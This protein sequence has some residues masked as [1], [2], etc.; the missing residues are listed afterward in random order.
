MA[1]STT[2]PS[3]ALISPSAIAKL[4]GVSAA[5][6]SNWRKRAADFPE[7]VAGDNPTRPLFARD[8][9]IAW[10][11]ANNKPIVGREVADTW[12]MLDT[13]RSALA[14][15]Q[16]ALVLLSLCAAR[17]LCEETPSP[18]QSWADLQAQAS[19]NGFEALRG[20]GNKLT[21]TRWD[22]LVVLGDEVGDVRPDAAA[23]IA[24]A[25]GQIP[26]KEL[27]DVADAVLARAV[28][29]LGRG[30]SELG[31]IGNPVS[32]FLAAISAGDARGTVYDPA[33]GIADVLIQLAAARSEA[34]DRLVGHD[35]NREVVTV[36]RQ[37]AYLHDV[38][39][40]L[41][42]TDVLAD[43]V[44]PDLTADLIVADPPYGVKFDGYD[45]LDPRWVYGTSK[46]SAELAWI[47]HAIAHLADD[48][49][50]YVATP[51]GTLF[52]SREKEIRRKLIADGCIQAI[53]QLP[54]RLLQHTSIAVAVWVLGKPGTSQSIRFVNADTA[55]VTEGRA[56]FESSQKSA[57]VSIDDVL[58]GDAN[59]VPER[60]IGM[61]TPDPAEV[62]SSYT[63]ALTRVDSS[64]RSVASV[65][66]QKFDATGPARIMT[67]GELADQGTL[68]IQ[69]GR[70]RA[71]RGEH[72]NDGRRVS[73]RDI[74]TGRI[75]TMETSGDLVDSRLTAAGDVLIATLGQLSTAVDES[76]GH[77]LGTG[78]AALRILDEQ[79]RPD[80]VAAVLRGWWNSR[81][82]TGQTVQRLS[83][84]DLEIPILTLSDQVAFAKA[85]ADLKEMQREAAQLHD[86]ASEAL[87][88]L[89]AIAR[90]GLDDQST[91]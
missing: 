33:C 78:V 6:V 2:N 32:R 89:T 62:A 11:N 30:G 15:E 86:A 34:I 64:I 50:A 58:A 77:L 41:G 48:G 74:A 10:M 46:A 53:Y 91:R 81:F 24:Q 18:S 70:P 31:Y 47:Q 54:P 21:I 9:V 56:G 40:E 51:G 19:E 37:R 12:A 5:A 17:K 1:R 55:E 16:A 36:A 25:I 27:A 61:D 22:E 72:K 7:P 23:L 66:V 85:A 80:Y 88:S 13:L 39:I 67:V 65:E 28:G 35:I 45:L 87:G 44:D 4:A 52:H 75:A 73:I 82:F 57:D 69:M 26:V 63:A 20:L 3:Q 29:A 43:D 68:Q 83:V 79:L 76:G 59:L 8:D 71:N 14:P 90:Y 84:R 38:D 42:I 49:I 60:W